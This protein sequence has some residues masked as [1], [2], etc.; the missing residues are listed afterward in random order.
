MS[1]PKEPRMR[2]I[3]MMYLVLTALLALNISAE[4]LNAF[5]LVNDGIKEA[6]RASDTKNAITYAQIYTQYERDPAR[7]QDAYDKSLEVKALAKEL[8]D[9]I[10]AVEEE[11]IELTGGWSK[12]DTSHL[13]SPKDIDKPS[14]LM[15]NQGKGEKLQAKIN[16]G[17]QRFLDI[18]GFTEEDEFATQLALSAPDPGKDK[19]G[20]TLTWSDKYFDFV[21][22]VA[23]LTIFSSLKNDV[24]NAEAA[25]I[26]ALYGSIGGT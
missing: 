20:R 10:T 25:V 14:T 21:P 24:K 2:M 18:L 1:I 5:Y 8:V 22:A 16:E 23:C 3:M 6:S 17:R 13:E 11:L 12:K 4:I 26:T 9:Y 7:A 19:K 15:I